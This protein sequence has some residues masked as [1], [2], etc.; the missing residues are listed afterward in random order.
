MVHSTRFIIE[1]FTPRISTT[2][3]TMKPV[4]RTSA[5]K[6]TGELSS[7]RM[8]SV[9]MF[10]DILIEIFIIPLFRGDAVLKVPQTKVSCSQGLR[11]D[12]ITIFYFIILTFYLFLRRDIN[13]FRL[14]R[15]KRGR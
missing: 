10:G 11:R 9:H 1:A 5:L 12:F 3:R 2:E 15:G 14:F 7:T 8:K 6:F 4:S 13:L